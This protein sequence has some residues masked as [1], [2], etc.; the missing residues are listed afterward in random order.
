MQPFQIGIISFNN[1][2]LSFLYIFHAI[3]IAYFILALKLFHRL[4]VP[5][6]IHSPIEGQG[7]PSWLSDK[8]L[9]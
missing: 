8:N 9:A 1:M 4:K 5:H 7:L 2:H 6:F 3:L